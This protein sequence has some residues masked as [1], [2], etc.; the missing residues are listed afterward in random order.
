MNRKPAS[1]P[2]KLSILFVASAFTT[3]DRAVE[4]I[5]DHLLRK[6]FGLEFAGGEKPSNG[7]CNP[8]KTSLINPK[9]DVVI[10]SN[11]AI[12]SRLNKE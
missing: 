8:V 2:F 9:V 10:R 6:I 4:F 3:K 11:I 1:K 12:Y 5:H 7:C